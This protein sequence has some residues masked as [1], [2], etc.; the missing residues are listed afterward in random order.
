MLRVSW[1]GLWAGV[2]ATAGGA[3]AL[4]AH[5][6]A[7]PA[8]VAALTPHDLQAWI[9]A[10]ASGIGAIAA[11]LNGVAVVVHKFRRLQAPAPP[12]RRRR[13]PAARPEGTPDAA[14]HP[15]GPDAPHPAP[16]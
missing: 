13:K 15:I 14:P 4:A 5:V 12:K 8:T 3:E 2:V 7:G 16:A 6:A 1:L 9:T 11:A 10:V